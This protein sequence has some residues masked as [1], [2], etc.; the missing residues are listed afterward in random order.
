MQDHSILFSVIIPTYNRA[1]LLKLAIQSVLDQQYQ[2]WELIVVD[3]GSTDETAEIVQKFSDPRICYVYQENQKLSAARNTG[4]EHCK[5]KYVCFLDDD[6]YYLE[7]HLINFYNWLFE[8]NFPEIILR[9]AFIYETRK[10]RIKGP[11]YQKEIHEN[12]LKF[13][14]YNFCASVTLCI[15]KLCFKEDLFIEGTEPWEDTHL[16]LRMFAKYP[17]HQLPFYTY[18]Y[19]KHTFMGSIKLYTEQDTLKLATQNVESMR[20]LFKNYG[21]LVNPFLPDYTERFIV[22]EK[23]S[24]HAFNAVLFGKFN[25]G[26]KLFRLAVKV[27]KRLYQW[28]SYLKFFMLFPVKW[29]TG[30]PKVKMKNQ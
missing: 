14:A 21:E 16:M 27:D 25:V 3:D 8:N 26:W 1:N 12:P 28:K 24:Q 22:A 7:N 23:Y 15:P 30:Y 10:G 20:H 11:F 13:A 5:G 9:S 29:L 19:V 18:V 4:I 17:F 6:D 2:N